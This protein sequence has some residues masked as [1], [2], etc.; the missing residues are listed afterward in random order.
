MEPDKSRDRWVHFPKGVSE[1][2]AMIQ[3]LQIAANPTRFNPRPTPDKK[4]GKL[5]C[6]IFN[7]LSLGKTPDQAS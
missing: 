3:R 2:K 7:D 1:E 5:F 6:F 4:T